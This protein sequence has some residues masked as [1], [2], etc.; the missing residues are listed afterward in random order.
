MGISK[1]HFIWFTSIVGATVIGLIAL[2]TLPTTLPADAERLRSLPADKAV[3]TYGFSRPDEARFK[4]DAYLAGKRPEVLLIGNH[5]IQFMSSHAFGAVSPR[6]YFFNMSSGDEALPGARDLVALLKQ[7][8]RLPK[9]TLLV[10]ITTP[11]NDNGGAILTYGGQLPPTVIL[12]SGRLTIAELGQFF[13]I[14]YSESVKQALSFG[15]VY[16]NLLSV[17]SAGKIYPKNCFERI[18]AGR[19]SSE[20][21]VTR[22]LPFSVRV[23]FGIIQDSC[24]F[25]D[26]VGTVYRPDGSLMSWALVRNWRVRLNQNPLIPTKSHLLPGDEIRVSNLMREIIDMGRSGNIKV[27]FVVMPVHAT[28]R[29]SLPNKIFSKATAKIAPDNLLDHRNFRHKSNPEYFHDYDH[30]NAKYFQ[31]MGKE[32]LDRK[33]VPSLMG[34]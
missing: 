3:F 27:V 14:Y 11:D 15:T 29:P 30:P 33:L 31:I 26:K 25:V 16:A 5:Q 28:D 13:G 6:D 1:R 4:I 7:K 20:T 19:L 8:G 21:D 12:A 24:R 22:Y 18:R 23:K 10:H 32:L 2:N 9:S 17:R 34:Q